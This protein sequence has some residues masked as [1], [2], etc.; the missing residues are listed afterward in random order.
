[1]LKF[2]I[3]IILSCLVL[4]QIVSDSASYQYP[5]NF[6]NKQTAVECLF[7]NC[8]LEGLISFDAFSKAIEGFEKYHPLKSI[9]AICDFTKPSDQNRFLVIDLEHKKLILNS[10]VAHGKNSGDRFANY[11]S[12][13]MHSLKSSLGFYRIGQEIISP[14]HG[15]AILLEGL[16]KGKNDLARK[17][18]IIIHGAQY[19]STDFIKKNGRLGRSYGCAA[20]P[21]EIMNTIAPILSNGA[22]LYIYNN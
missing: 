2:R 4:C 8:G 10:L 21:V 6:A 15:K 9:L 11:F 20:L 19:V 7:Q 17:R 12:N 3:L 5:Q 13:Q 16:E 18:E 14:K 22:L 1:M